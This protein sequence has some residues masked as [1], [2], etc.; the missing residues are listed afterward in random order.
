MSARVARME[1]LERERA[2]GNRLADKTNGELQELLSACYPGKYRRAIE[3]EM[4]RRLRTQEPA[5]PWERERSY[6]AQE[7]SK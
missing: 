1:M 7:P 4:E 5:L 6:P 3:A 2:Y